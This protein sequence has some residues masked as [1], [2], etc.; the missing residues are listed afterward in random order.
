MG[1]NRISAIMSEPISIP[2]FEIVAPNFF[3]NPFMKMQVESD[4]VTNRTYFIKD[5]K[6][7]AVA[8]RKD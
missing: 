1:N 2:R 4:P 5:G 7:V 6:I 8:L 3:F